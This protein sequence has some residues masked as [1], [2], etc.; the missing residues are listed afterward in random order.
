MVVL[1]YLNTL[2]SFGQMLINTPAKNELK[3]LVDLYQ[4]KYMHIFI[5]IK[6]LNYETTEFHL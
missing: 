4:C 2:R 1:L 5:S 3:S 6:L